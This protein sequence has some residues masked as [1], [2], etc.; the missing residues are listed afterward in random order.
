[1][2]R[3]LDG[4]RKRSRHKMQKSRKAKGKVSVTRFF[5][6][7][8]EGDKAVLNAEPAYQKGIYPLQFHGKTGT[9]K[10]KKG[11]CYRLDL[12]DGK[13]KALVVHP[14]HLKKA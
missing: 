9:V 2:V 10:G 4:A 12:K 8:K 11:R 14:I 7:F 13:I 3:R 1:M 5:Q 6:E